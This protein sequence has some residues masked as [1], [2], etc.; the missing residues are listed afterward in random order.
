MKRFA[1]SDTSV[2]KLYEKKV[3]EL[4]HEKKTLQVSFLFAL[5]YVVKLIIYC[6]AKRSYNFNLQREIEEL[7]HNLSNISSTSGDGAQKLKEDYLHKLNLLE[8]QVSRMID[9]LSPFDGIFI[10]PTYVFCLQVSEL[11]KKQDAQAQALRQKQKSDEAARRLQDEIQR[12]KTQKVLFV[13]K[14]FMLLEND[15]C[16]YLLIQGCFPG[17][18]ATQDQTGV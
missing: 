10:S 14:L 13:V 3:Q 5:L 11:K 4:E 15:D 7:R 12:I 18:I 16:V 8:G 17:A 6:L 1:S 2:I 9:D